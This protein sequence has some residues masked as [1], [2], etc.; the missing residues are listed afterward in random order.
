MKIHEH[1]Y[2]TVNQRVTPMNVPVQILAEMNFV[3]QELVKEFVLRKERNEP[4]ATL[5]AESYPNLSLSGI[6]I[7]VADACNLIFE[8]FPNSI[9]WH[10]IAESSSSIGMVGEP[11]TSE[12]VGLIISALHSF[13]LNN[14]MPE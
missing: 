1:L 8:F 11:T 10:R 14:G 2:Y 6:L 5:L 12:Y 3:H 7:K 4:K 9:E 13:I